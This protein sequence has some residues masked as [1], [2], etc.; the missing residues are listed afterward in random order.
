MHSTAMTPSGEAPPRARGRRLLA[1]GRGRIFRQFRQAR[2][3]TKILLLFIVASLVPLYALYFFA[4][5]A[6]SDI[7]RRQQLA[8]LTLL[9]TGL[10]S[11]IDD[12]LDTW[13]NDTKRLSL[14]PAVV[15]SFSGSTAA[16]IN[17]A[18]HRDQATG[19]GTRVAFAMDLSGR[20]VASS[21]PA[22]N[23]STEF[24]TTELFQQ[25]AKGNAYTS[26]LSIGHLVPVPAIYFS[27]PVR[28]ALGHVLGVVAR[29]QDPGKIFSFF[30]AG[31]L[32]Q[33]RYA[34]LLDQNGIVIGTSGPPQTLYH[35]L[36]TLNPTEQQRLQ[37]NGSFGGSAV[38]SL[39]MNELGELITGATT[40][41]S[42]KA[43]FS[44]MR[45][46]TV[47][48]FSPLKA[49]RWEIAVAQ[50]EEVFLA[51]VQQSTRN[52]VTFTTLVAA[53]F[54]LILFMVARMFERAERQ[55]H[56]DSL[57]GLPNRRYFHDILG[58][59]LL[60]S[61]RNH[62]PLSL[63]NVDLDHFKMVN[64]E[65]GHAKG[66]E[67]LRGFARVLKEQV[68]SIDLPVRYGGEEFL[69]LLP[70]T[71]KEGAVMVA[72][73]I[74]RATD[75]LSIPRLGSIPGRKLTAS[76]GVACH[77][78]DAAD[79]EQLVRYSD[80]A[81]YL[82]KNLGR[83]Q[84]VGYGMESGITSLTGHP[85]R[86]HMLV[87]NANKAT[88]EAL[89]AAIDARDT[90]THGHSHRVAD[91]AKII[92]TEAEDA[93]IDLE[94]LYLGALL[95]DVG[96]IGISD[97]LLRKPSRLTPREYETIKGH[98]Q[99]GYEMLQ[100]V[101]FLRSVAPIIL[102]HHENYGGSG[103][104][105][106]ISGKAIPIES[107]IIMISDAFDA[108]TSTRT[109][110]EAGSIEKALVELRKHAGRQFDPDLVEALARAIRKGKLR[111]LSERPKTQAQLE[112]M[113]AEAGSS[114]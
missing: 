52:T 75:R 13:S 88:I 34:M 95:H 91:Y 50:P 61:S 110:R 19:A 37:R 113:A 107:R 30:S 21:D 68:R 29:R 74:R 38:P 106:G 69:V 71:D 1:A 67:I 4:D 104:P 101:D 65:Y 33:Q 15:A 40:Y 78:Q 83:N 59:E 3:S 94:S 82:A 48:G 32:G 103:Y 22:I 16:D 53:V 112:T 105:S 49:E 90:Y 10:A 12:Q 14:E 44:P 27:A 99:I 20:V 60:R 79:E 9:S 92:A 84:V 2:T 77:P 108:M 31:N 89:A 66:D 6:N 7:L 55:S 111:L 93:E 36:G 47:F 57:T 80:Q 64:D 25:A 70:D 96:K 114:A 26:D 24:A 28:D 11:Q 42:A 17:E 85:E 18:V 23:G 8:N 45:Q 54:V 43:Y 56:T 86:V 63:I 46:Q 62:R 5:Q 58:R 73:K 76:A 41:G 35:S 87:Q 97:V 72:E 39:G 98:A 51:P 102:H 100:G 81:M 109:Y